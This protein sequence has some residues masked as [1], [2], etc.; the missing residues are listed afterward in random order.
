MKKIADLSNWNDFELRLRELNDERQQLKKNSNSGYVSNLLFRGQPNADWPLT[1]TLERYA[2]L[3]PDLLSASNYYRCICAAKPQIETYTGRRWAI[4]Q[5]PQYN[6]RLRDRSF[7]HKWF[8]GQIYEYMVFLRHHGFPSP[9]LDWSLSPYLAAFFAFRDAAPGAK[10][11]A[12]YAFLEYAGKGKTGAGGVPKISDLGQYV[13]SHRRHFIQQSEYTVC[14][15]DSRDEIF[16]SSHQAAFEKSEIGQDILW[17]I[18]LPISQ[19]L[20]ILR[21]LDLHNINSLSLFGSDEGLM[22]TVAFRELKLRE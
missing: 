11:V 14:T 16:F 22:E 20:E 21:I 6:D 18:T 5:P 17:K 2:F 3:K 12:V 19:R 13:T 7:V 4:D 1:T 9:L 15:V 10:Q 8:E